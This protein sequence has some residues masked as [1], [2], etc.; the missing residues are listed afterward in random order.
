VS[1]S[2]TL[3]PSQQE[4]FTES[5]KAGARAAAIAGATERARELADKSVLRFQADWFRPAARTSMRDVIADVVKD[6]LV[7][8]AA[9]VELLMEHV[10]SFI[11]QEQMMAFAEHLAKLPAA[12]PAGKG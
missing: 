2:V 9:Q 1:E 11:P 3:T 7:E 8:D 5:M 6:A 4:Q 12:A 10:L